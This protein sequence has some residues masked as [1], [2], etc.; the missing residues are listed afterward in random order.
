[1]PPTHQLN[2]LRVFL[3]SPNDLEDERRATKEIVDRLNSTIRHIGWVVELLAW[4]D[5]TPGFGRPQEQINEDVDACDLFL[6]ILWRRWGSPSGSF[7]SGFEEEFERAVCR[8]RQSESPE[9]WIYFK[10]VEDASDPGEQL[11]RVLAFREDVERRRELLFG[12]FCTIS[13]WRDACYDALMR[14]VLKRASPEVPEIQSTASPA[15]PSRLGA[16]I[17]SGLPHS[18]RQLP[19]QLLRVSEELGHAAREP[20]AARFNAKLLAREDF[21]LV[22]L[23]L[24]GAS[25]L[26]ERVSQDPLS[27]HAANLVYRHRDKLGTLTRPELRLAIESML[28]EGNSYVPGWYWIKAIPDEK[29]AQN[30]ESVVIDHSEPEVRTSTLNLLASRPVLPGMTRTNELVDA[31]LGDPPMRLAALEYGALY[32]DSSTA[33]VIDGRVTDMPEKLQVAARGVIAQILARHDPNRLLDRLLDKNGASYDASITISSE[34]IPTLDDGKLRSMLE[35]KSSNLRL[36]AAD[37]L[38]RGKLLTAEEAKALLEDSELRVRAIGIRRLISLGEPLTPGDIRDLLASDSTTK[39]AMALALIRSAQNS[40]S[41]DELV[42]ELF[43]ALSYDE[44]FPLVNWF[45]SDGRCAYKVLGLKHFE[46]FGD[47]VRKDLADRFKTF[48]ETEKH[49]LRKR[50]LA[51][52]DERPSSDETISAAVERVA[53]E[54]IENWSGLDDIITSEFVRAAL[55]AL[56]K[57]GSPSD[58]PKARQHLNSEDGASAEA[59]VELVSR[60]GNSSDVEPLLALAERA[61]G[62]VA[63]RAAETALALSE[64][65]WVRAMQYVERQAKPFLRIGIDALT[66][67]AEFPSRWPEL[68]PYLSVDNTNARLETAKLLCNRLESEDQVRILKQCLEGETY[69]YDVVTV[70]DRSLYGPTAWRTV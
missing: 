56:A 64:D 44:L 52:L 57:N 41:P 18:K 66:T 24:L 12:R 3:A 49:S 37:T 59:A 34:A 8:R 7:S 60:F 47:R 13:E 4:E 19:E 39:P 43:S 15:A 46:R 9:V 32:G 1:M 51:V 67:H 29:V 30:L 62:R 61:Y 45:D 54:A 40:P 65:R 21:D 31:G 26:Y 11:R 50:F 35:H 16:T 17:Q 22:R 27:N 20:S 5:R 55:T 36:M 38:A 68:M 42:E 63:E 23:H 70:L 2:V 69:H 58:L 10:C 48:H 33:D 14:Y 28:C 6:G 53:A 25:L